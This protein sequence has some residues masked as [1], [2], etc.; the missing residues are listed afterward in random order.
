MQRAVERAELR[1]ELARL[2][3]GLLDAEQ[4]DCLV[5]S[6]QHATLLYRPPPT[7][8]RSQRRFQGADGSG[9]CS[10]SPFGAVFCHDVQKL[11]GLSCTCCCIW[12]RLNVLTVRP[13]VY[14]CEL[15]I[16]CADAADCV[17]CDA[18]L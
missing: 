15:A 16:V 10:M 8:L 11:G 3:T 5:S 9:V 6:Q 2:W 12:V 17:G 7:L 4:G 14:V 18:Q 13:C 1:E